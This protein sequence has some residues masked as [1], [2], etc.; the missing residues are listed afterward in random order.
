MNG[1]AQTIYLLIKHSD[2]LLLT[3]S[4][5]NATS[6]PLCP[7]CPGAFST[8]SAVRGKGTNLGSDQSSGITVNVFTFNFTLQKS[9]NEGE[10]GKEKHKIPKL[11]QPWAFCSISLP[12]PSSE[13]IQKTRSTSSNQKHLLSPS[14]LQLRQ[15]LKASNCSH[16]I[17]FYDSYSTKASEVNKTQEGRVVL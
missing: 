7:S 2:L 4:E 1:W 6:V 8:V 16:L 3:P 12:L 11:H 15:H 17:S 13:V 14:F 9:L 5:N 10:R